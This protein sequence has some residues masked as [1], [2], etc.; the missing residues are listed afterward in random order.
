M[1]LSQQREHAPD[2][3]VS[4][5]RAEG[6][7]TDWAYTIINIVRHDLTVAGWRVELWFADTTSEPGTYDANHAIETV[8]AQSPFVPYK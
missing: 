5:H 3:A 2:I 6:P 4:R 1:T 7:F 8:W